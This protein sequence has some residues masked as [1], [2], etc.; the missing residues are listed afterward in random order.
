M[1]DSA[2]SASISQMGKDGLLV[3][4]EHS[5]ILTMYF[6]PSCTPPRKLRV[7]P[8]A[9]PS[10]EG[11]HFVVHVDNPQQEE[12]SGPGP[13]HDFRND[14]SIENV[15]FTDGGMTVTFSSQAEG[16]LKHGGKLTLI[17]FFRG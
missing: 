2:S 4:V 3:K 6:A 9:N 5:G 15:E 7:E 12:E 8:W 11:C 13:F 1:G 17:D 10:L 14:D 16:P